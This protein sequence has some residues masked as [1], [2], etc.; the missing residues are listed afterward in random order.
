MLSRSKFLNIGLFILLSSSLFAQQSETGNLKVATFA[1]G[2]FWCMEPPFD[3]L[4]GVVSTTSGYIGGHV[5]NPSYKQ[6]SSGTTGHIEAVQ[7]KYDPSLI[8]YDKLLE[9][10][11]KNVDPTR[12]D[13]QFCD[14]GEQYRPAVFY[15]DEEQKNLVQKQKKQLSINKP[16]PEMVKVEILEASMFYEA[17]EYHQ[18]YYTKNPVRYKFYRYKCGRDK[19]LQEVW[20]EDSV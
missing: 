2:C 9:V 18:D 3:K 16:F 15:H 19:R 7:I 11:W 1:G 6:V 8:T 14:F 10:F 4:D 17:E 13:G 20:G 5:E 12:S